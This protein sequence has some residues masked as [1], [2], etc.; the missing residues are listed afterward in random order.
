MVKLSEVYIGYS[1][2]AESLVEKAT[3]CG[4]FLLLGSFKNSTEKHSG[5]IIAGIIVTFY[6]ILVE[7]M[8]NFG[9]FHYCEYYKIEGKLQY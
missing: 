4:F 3:A 7:N 2:S 8:D 6:G 9:M 1:Y 5:L